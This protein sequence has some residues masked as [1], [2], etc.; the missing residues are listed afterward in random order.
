MGGDAPQ[1]GTTSMQQQIT[2]NVAQK[3][4]K[5][6]RNQIFKSSD[7]SKSGHSNSF[8]APHNNNNNG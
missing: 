4:Q 6:L 7:Y 2:K 1:N 8:A 5:L 3:Q